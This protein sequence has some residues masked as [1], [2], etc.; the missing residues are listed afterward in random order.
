MLHEED[1]ATNE[2]AALLA[3][4]VWGT[5]VKPKAAAVSSNGTISKWKTRRR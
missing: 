4:H 5:D 1:A 3:A 2:V